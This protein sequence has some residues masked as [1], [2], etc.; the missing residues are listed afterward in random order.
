MNRNLFA[1]AAPVAPADLT[2][3]LAGGNAFAMGSEAQLAQ[4]VLTGT[5]HNTFYA[6]AKEDFARVLAL[7]ANVPAEFLAKLAVYG[8]QSGFMKD[9]PALL[10]AVLSVRDPVLFAKVFD[11][12]V[13]DAKMLRNFVQIVRS[14]VAGRKS[15]GSGP[16]A[17]V[18]QWLNDANVNR[19]LNGTVGSDPSLA[20]VIKLA[21]PKPL[22]KEREAFYGWVLGKPV[23]AACLPPRVQELLAFRADPA[24]KS[25]PPVEF[26]LVDH[27][28]GDAQWK[29]VARNASWQMTRIN[30][31]TFMRHGVYEDVELV[32][33]IAD[34]LAN[35]A[36][37]AQSKVMPYQLLAA[38]R[39]SHNALPA[40][41]VE[42]L[43]AALDMAVDNVPALPGRVAVCPDVSGSMQSP[44]TGRSG[45]PS[46]VRCIDVA[47]L[48]TASILAKN[49]DA[50]VL[51]FDSAVRDVR[52]SA[53]DSVLTNAEKLASIRGGATAVSAPLRAL[54]HSRQ[55]VDA[56]VYVSDYESWRDADGALGRVDGRVGVSTA[57]QN[58]W[59]VYKRIAPAA[60]LVALDVTPNATVQARSAADTLNIGGFS[61]AV[62][63]VV[64][65][66]LK[67]EV[68]TDGLVQVVNA[69]PL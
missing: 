69:V 62:F 43:H 48:V 24:G 57:T 40:L 2:K 66:F 25:V 5:F 59:D 65:A 37:I 15:L 14:G 8:R 36:L 51:P 6:D 46:K 30:L 17:R 38:Y 47:A 21:R 60:K 67:G 54:V 55:V 41:L 56:V 10:L 4:Y 58:L 18:A 28:L 32:R 68:G 12:V 11:R 50:L 34:R 13:D 33:V 45:V 3:N 44:V 26:R 1:S 20:D 7:A 35:R 31:N 64:N 49:K 16:Q 42:A 9:S 22:N 39:H 63:D 61:D 52:L 19:L 27:Y 53:R 29:D 23:D